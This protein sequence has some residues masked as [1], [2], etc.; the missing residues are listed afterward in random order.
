MSKTVADYVLE[1]LRHWGVEVVFGY[2][3]DGINGLLAAWGRADNIPTFVQARHEEMSA[4]EA[5]GRGR[6]RSDAPPR[7]RSPVARYAHRRCTARGR[8]GRCPAAL[9]VWRLLGGRRAPALLPA[10]ATE[11]HER[12]EPRRAAVIRPRGLRRCHHGRVPG[13]QIGD[14][15]RQPRPF[16]NA[17]GVASGTSW[18]TCS[19][20]FCCCS[21]RCSAW[22]TRFTSRAGRWSRSTCARRSCSPIRAGAHPGRDRVQE[23]AH[24]A[25]WGSTPS[26]LRP[27]SASRTRATPSSRATPR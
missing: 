14:R 12:H 24:R 23:P 3:G 22:G 19:P 9:V 4:F 13:G 17:V 21:G 11:L 26:E 10:R 6:D 15:A 16:G 2:A 18:R 5:V 8:R 7:T 20:G 27:S 1:R 25:R